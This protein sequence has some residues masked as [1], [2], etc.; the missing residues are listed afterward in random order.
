MMGN[1]SVIWANVPG[2]LV[3]VVTTLIYSL[4]TDVKSMLPTFCVMAALAAT[5]LTLAF[6]DIQEDAAAAQMIAYIGIVQAV[7]MMGSGCAVWPKVVAENDSAALPPWPAV[8]GV[9]MG[10]VWAA[11]GWLVKNDPNIYGPNAL[12]MLC[13]ICSLVLIVVFPAGGGNGGVGEARDLGSVGSNRRRR[14]AKK[15]D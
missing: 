15:A 3:G 7:V 11:F 5:V 12:G 2:L 14:N 1:Q 8:A 4:H 10:G 9:F 13:N 6:G